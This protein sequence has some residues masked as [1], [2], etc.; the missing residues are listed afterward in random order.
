MAK[1]AITVFKI[2]V[3]GCAE[4]AKKAL[5]T[6][7]KRE[8]KRIMSADPKP[9]RFTRWVDGRQGAAEETV[10]PTGIIRYRYHRLEE[11]VQAAMETLFDLSPVESGEYRNAHTIFVNGAQSRNLSDWD[12]QESIV[13]LNPLPYSRKI[14][15]GIMKMRVPGS[16]HV[17][18]Q[19]ED[20]LRRRFN[21]QASVVFTYRG[22]VGGGIAGAR[23]GGNKSGNRYPA[24]VITPR[25]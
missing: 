17:Y 8:H 18:E 1:S 4:Q 10:K 7:A 5:I 22:Y 11:I 2:A 13:I 14:E 20:I 24:L 21:N 9:A 6:T 15:L 3:Q 23:A 19:A 12:G 16:D 25:R